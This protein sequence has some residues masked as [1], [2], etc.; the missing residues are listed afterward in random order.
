MA[1]FKTLNHPQAMSTARVSA[2]AQVAIS[3]LKSQI[4]FLRDSIQE[5]RVLQ[6]WD[7]VTRLYAEIGNLESRIRC[8][9]QHGREYL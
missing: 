9:T 5:A 2:T 6:Q 4:Q 7:R 3:T 1:P 8:L